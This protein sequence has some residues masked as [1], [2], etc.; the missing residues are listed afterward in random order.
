M[1]SELRTSTYATLMST[2]TA[3]KA[4]ASVVAD[5]P[6]THADVHAA[7]LDAMRRDRGND[8]AIN[9]GIGRST[10]QV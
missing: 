4:S 9:A 3:L 7:K 6:R 1:M 10:S 8:A 5:E 2:L